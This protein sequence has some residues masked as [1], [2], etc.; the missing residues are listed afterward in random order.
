MQAVRRYALGDARPSVPA[1]DTSFYS[2]VY[3][4]LLKV[5]SVKRCGSSGI[6]SV[7]VLVGGALY[8]LAHPLDEREF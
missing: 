2:L 4:S 1:G 7:R 6:I 8:V 3:R 5:L